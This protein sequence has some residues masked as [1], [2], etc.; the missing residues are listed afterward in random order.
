[1]PPSKQMDIYEAAKYLSLSPAYVRMN[2]RNGIIKSTRVPT[3]EGS[4]VMKHMVTEKELRAFKDREYARAPRREDGRAKC[5]FYATTD[6]VN[7][8]KELL[9]TSNDPGL[10]VVALSI[11]SHSKGGSNERFIPRSKLEPT[12]Q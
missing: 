10:A 1:M 11:T 6:E 3:H 9:Y 7:L 12:S 4:R 5:C 8:I 2:I